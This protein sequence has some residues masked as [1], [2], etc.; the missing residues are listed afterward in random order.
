M[1]GSSIT[2]LDLIID[3]V[4]QR[5]FLG[6]TEIRLR[7]KTFAVLCYMMEHPERLVSKAELVAAVWPDIRVSDS[8]LKVCIREIRQA[9]GEQVDSP[10]FIRTEGRR[11]YWFIPQVTA[12][13][14]SERSRPIFAIDGSEGAAAAIG[15]IRE[16]SQLRRLFQAS[17]EGQRQVVLLTGEAGSGKTSLAEDFLEKIR[18]EGQAWVAQGRC[19][20][21]RG[22]GEPGLVW[23][24]LLGDLLQ[25]LE[26][27]RIVNLL[28][29][30]APTWI[31]QMPELLLS[32]EAAPRAGAEGAAPRLQRELTE[33]FLA[34]S[35]EH[36]LVLALDDVQ[37]ADAI[38]LD[39]L[40]ALARRRQPA[41]LLV[42]ALLRPED[43]HWNDHPAHATYRDLRL[44]RL[45][46]EIALAPLMLQQIMVLVEQ[47]ELRGRRIPELPAIV[48]R[49]SAG[50]L[51]FCASLITELAQ[52]FEQ[53][54]DWS[55]CVLLSA[56]ERTIPNS[57]RLLLE[58]RWVHLSADERRCLE[59]A[60]IL[61]TTFRA[62]DLAEVL[63][64]P[65]ED[66]DALCSRLAVRHFLEPYGGRSDR[67]TIGVYRFR[68]PILQDAILRQVSV[69]RRE[70]I[71]QWVRANRRLLN[72]EDVQI[73]AVLDA[74]AP[75]ITSEASRS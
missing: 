60:S 39:V 48:Q 71:Q 33:F 62:S 65:E 37:V 9:L 10:R 54:D 56:A 46:H 4:N 31:S 14:T 66:I 51:R 30:H 36:P 70:R 45:V 34:L 73:A 18:A 40:A 43:L 44:H 5:A 53:L 50:N 17:I 7:P 72:D 59:S 6:G 64:S 3:V 75:D 42:L 32:N 25:R 13:R 20:E 23:M 52:R 38:T 21:L 69:A 19:V 28:R 22:R 29:R 27:D 11:G 47:S 58:Q 15:R 35:N 68:H 74:G 24:E 41:R 2:A 26:R 67:S 12:L 1:R 55:P 16:I 49:R 8:A 61:G 63:E 57:V